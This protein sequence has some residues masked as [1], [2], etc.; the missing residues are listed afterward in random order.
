M[1]DLQ[2]RA[3][4]LRRAWPAIVAMLTACATSHVIVGQTRAPISPDEVR[5]YLH[6]PAGHYEEIAI[7]D[8]SSRNS[9]SF[10]AQGKADAVV[11]RLKRDAASLGANGILLQNVGDEAVGSVG[12]GIGTGAQA[13]HASLGIGVGGSDTKFVKSGRGIAIYVEPGGVQR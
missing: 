5:L 3:P 8:T 2:Q 4:A 6:P 12:A 9:L 11:D 13:G 1:P 10:T 7:L